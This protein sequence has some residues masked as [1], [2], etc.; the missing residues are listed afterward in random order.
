M[1]SQKAAYTLNGRVTEGVWL[2][3][4]TLAAVSRVGLWCLHLKPKRSEHHSFQREIGQWVIKTCILATRE[5]LL[6]VFPISQIKKETLGL[7]SFSALFSSSLSGILSHFLTKNNSPPCSTPITSLPE[8]LPLAFGNFS[9]KL[10]GDV[11]LTPKCYPNEISV[12]NL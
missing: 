12:F 10:E 6:W 4:N 5:D 1:N 2:P 8:T 7:V 9:M 11:Y 3:K